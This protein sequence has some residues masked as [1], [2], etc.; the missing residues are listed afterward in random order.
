MTRTIICVL[1][2]GGWNGG[3]HPVRYEP[4]NVQ[5]LQR[6]AQKHAPKAPFVCLSDVDVPGVD[7]I[8]IEHDWPG[9]WPKI[10]LFK[11][12]IG[13]VLY[14]DLDMV[15]TGPLDS[16][17]NYPHKFT[18][19][20]NPAKTARSMNSSVM[21]W[22]GPR[23]DIYDPFIADPKGWMAKCADKSCWG[24]QGFIEQHVTDWQ[25]WQSLFPGAVMSYKQDLKWRDPKPDTRIVSFHGKPKPWEAKQRWVPC[26]N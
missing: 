3:Y 14:L 6:Q 20:N 10:E 24:D 18:A 11:L 7:V 5:W 9:W 15:L 2:T 17:M 23:P 21:A 4:R 22:S 26:L 1:R 19:W 12:D 16:L 8:P 13:P 25:S